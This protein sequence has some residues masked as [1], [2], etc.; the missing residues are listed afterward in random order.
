MGV[1]QLAEGGGPGASAEVPKSYEEKTKRT[2]EVVHSIMN[3]I[4]PDL[5]F[6]NQFQL[7]LKAVNIK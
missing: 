1:Y 4:D 6:T 7:N 2:S 3:D 5:Q